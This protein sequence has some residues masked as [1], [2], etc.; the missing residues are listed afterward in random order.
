MNFSQSILNVNLQVMFLLRI[1]I[2]IVMIVFAY[3][4]LKK[5]ADF[6]LKRVPSEVSNSVNNLKKQAKEVIKK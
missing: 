1:I 5:G 6:V 2:F 4:Y 3:P